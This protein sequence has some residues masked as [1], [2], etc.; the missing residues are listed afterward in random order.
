[1]STYHF[2]NFRTRLMTAKSVKEFD[3]KLEDKPNEI[4]LHT[5]I[6]ARMDWERYQGKAHYWSGG[7]FIEKH[8]KEDWQGT[9]QLTLEWDGNVGPRLL[10]RLEELGWHYVLSDTV[11]D[12]GLGILV[13]FPFEYEITDPETYTRVAAILSYLIGIP[14]LRDG[15]DAITY[16]WQ[17]N[18]NGTA[19][20]ECEQQG[21]LIDPQALRKKHPDSKWIVFDDMVGKGRKREAP[22]QTPMTGDELFQWGGL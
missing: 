15:S 4:G 7:R 21:H 8:R 14:G 6:S 11:N 17:W 18:L 1:M 12:D 22:K 3:C 5:W 9:S 19:P 20:Y 13:T 2:T 16:L 10:D